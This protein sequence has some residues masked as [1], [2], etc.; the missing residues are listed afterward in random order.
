MNPLQVYPSSCFAAPQQVDFSLA[1]SQ[2]VLPSSALDSDS[3]I[4]RSV[5]GNR[6]RAN[7]NRQIELVPKSVAEVLGEYILRPTLNYTWHCGCKSVSWLRDG[8]VSLDKAVTRLITIF[9]GALAQSTAVAV[10]SNDRCV[11]LEAYRDTL[12]SEDQIRLTDP[13]FHKRYQEAIR[14]KKDIDNF[15]S[16]IG[17]RFETFRDQLESYDQSYRLL[18]EKVTDIA[19]EA[20]AQGLSS[21]YS[22][23]KSTKIDVTFPKMQM[24]V[25]SKHTNIV[26]K[27]GE[28][29]IN[30]ENM[31]GVIKQENAATITTDALEERIR[32]KFKEGGSIALG[33]IYNEYNKT[34]H[35]V[36]Q[37]KRVFSDDSIAIAGTFIKEKKHEI[38]KLAEDYTQLV[39]ALFD[40]D[41]EKIR[42]SI[43]L[44]IKEIYNEQQIL[45][46]QINDRNKKDGK[47]ERYSIENMLPDE[48]GFPSEWKVVKKW[49]GT[50]YGENTDICFQIYR[51]K[52]PK[53][54]TPDYT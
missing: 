51:E 39:R 34:P 7:Q 15:I 12:S 5:L 25:G 1:D 41:H 17:K 32:K 18:E 49:P 38:L 16:D 4:D 2:L 29:W 33:V 24:M 21:K 52:L 54:V 27:K 31:L 53:P 30:M 50:I 44:R 19:T 23:L 28:L 35:T 43:V 42:K 40:K 8:F 3:I 37:F 22:L 47:K 20:I 26:V 48:N 10:S 45:I 6:L 14:L 46:N 36:E 9:P 11:D 13:K